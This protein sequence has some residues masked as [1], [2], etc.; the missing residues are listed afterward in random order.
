MEKQQTKPSEIS[1]EMTNAPSQLLYMRADFA[2]G[3]T[4][5]LPYVET[6]IIHVPTTFFISPAL[7]MRTNRTELQ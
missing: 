7:L 2:L 3:Q 4:S 5:S 6:A 1:W